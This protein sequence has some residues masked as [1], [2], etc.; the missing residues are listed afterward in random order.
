MKKGKSIFQFD[1]FL[2]LDELSIQKL[3]R[4]IEAPILTIALKNAPT[5]IKEK[6]YLTMPKSA[7]FLYEEDIKFLGEIPEERIT[8][9]RGN[10]SAIGTKLLEEGEISLS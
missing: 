6:I 3:L 4:E 9:A 7:V 2:R 1:D 5:A 10:I 8:E